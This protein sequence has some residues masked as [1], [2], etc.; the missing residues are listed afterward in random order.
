MSSGSDLTVCELPE[1]RAQSS[2]FQEIEVEEH[3]TL[4]PSYLGK[5][6]SPSYFSR[7]RRV[8]PPQAGWGRAWS[9]S[10]LAECFSITV[11]TMGS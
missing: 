1:M 4:L 7:A 3:V 9:R 2:S 5:V 6:V 10:W 11:C 8:S